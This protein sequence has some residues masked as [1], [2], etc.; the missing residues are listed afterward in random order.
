MDASPAPGDPA[1]Q[2]ITDLLAGLGTTPAGFN[3]TSVPCPNGQIVTVAGFSGATD[4]GRLT[5]RLS[6]PT[7][8]R[9]CLVPGANRVAY[10]D[11]AI[12]VVVDASDD[13][14]AMTVRRTVTC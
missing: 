9:P 8:A 3:T 5:D 11:G 1:V 12:S 2:T 14:A 7:G 4:S 10:R 6:P 13:G